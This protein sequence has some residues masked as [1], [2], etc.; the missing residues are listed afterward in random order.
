MR[1]AERLSK[2]P[3]FSTVSA[4]AGHQAVR[5]LVAGAAFLDRPRVEFSRR[6]GWAFANG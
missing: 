1:P 6:A 5:G 2:A 4:R 3:P